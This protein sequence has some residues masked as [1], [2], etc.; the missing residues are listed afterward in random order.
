MP[1]NLVLNHR[2]AISGMVLASQIMC[3]SARA[4]VMLE[5][6]I[7]RK[8]LLDP[9]RLFQTCGQSRP[10]SCRNLV[11]TEIRHPLFANFKLSMSPFDRDNIGDNSTDI[12][13]S[14]G[15]AGN[16]RFKKTG[17]N[18]VDDKRE[19]PNFKVK[20]A[21]D[22]AN[23]SLAKQK[24]FHDVSRDHYNTIFLNILGSL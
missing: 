22:N 11:G 10:R 4:F 5:H 24:S 1:S 20:R 23:M 16:L 13:R 9:F 3:A 19:E 6:S 12:F 18:P 14:V 15:A 17:A 2:C 8:N 21:D 7:F